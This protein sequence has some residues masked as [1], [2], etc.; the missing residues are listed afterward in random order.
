MGACRRVRLIPTVDVLSTFG[1]RAFLAAALAVSVTILPAKAATE[2]VVHMLE[3]ACTNGQALH[4][5]VDTA[6]E[7]L[8]MGDF[9][10]YDLSREAARQFYKC[11][12]VTDYSYV[13][14]W[15]RYYYFAYLINSL[16]TWQETYTHGQVTLDGVAEL[17]AGSSFPDVRKA[18]EAMY[19]TFLARYE[20]AKTHLR[21]Y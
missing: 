7:A 2:S 21:I 11:A 15:A 20:Q 3:K 6:D 19:S 10:S 12:H 18:A 5:A 17:K 1:S 9:D 8:A 4:D 13:H 14:D 16:G